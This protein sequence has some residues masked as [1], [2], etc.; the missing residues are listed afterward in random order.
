M[1]DKALKTIGYVANRTGASVSALRFYADEG[2][3]PTVRAPSGHRLFHRSTI[4]RVAFI[5]ISQNLG[6]SLE[7]IKKALAALPNQ[8]TP[9]QSDW[10]KLAKRF[11]NEI[12]QRIFALQQL[13]GK[14][15]SCI[16]CGC[17]SMERCQLYNPGDTMS[18]KGAGAHLLNSD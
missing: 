2:L 17:L 11:G 5:L 9:T 1:E 14:L 3:I 6:Y 13:R 10:A 12:D 8:R 4:R 15:E 18:A 16:G 7:Q